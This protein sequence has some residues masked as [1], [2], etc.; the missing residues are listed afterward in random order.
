MQR[1]ASRVCELG[2]NGICCHRMYETILC[3][4]PFLPFNMDDVCADAVR[5]WG[6]GRWKG[7]IFAYLSAYNNN[8]V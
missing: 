3:S 2:E 6:G 4:L 8:I 7:G 1:T 5:R